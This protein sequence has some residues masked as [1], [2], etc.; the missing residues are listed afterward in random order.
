MERPSHIDFDSQ[1]RC[2]PCRLPYAGLAISLQCAAAFLFIY[3]IANHKIGNIIRD[4]EVPPIQEQKIDNRVKPPEPP[5]AKRIPTEKPIEPIIK[6][7]K[8]EGENFRTFLPS[9]SN[10]PPGVTR[11][12]DRALASIAGTHTVPPYPPIARRL[13]AEGKVTLRLTVS[14]EGRVTTAEIV[15]S[16]GREDMDQ[17]AQQWIMAHWT[18]KPALADGIPAV[19]HTLATVV[20]SLVNER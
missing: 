19:S 13:G 15:T 7:D 5:I 17:S 16:S 14:G 20:F 9:T 12:V 2:L 3:G 6:W 4:I 1:A 11:G 8:S 10:D 18:Y